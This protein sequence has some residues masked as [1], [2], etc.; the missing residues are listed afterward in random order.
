MI[1]YLEEAGRTASTLWTPYPVA[2]AQI[3][4]DTT[5]TRPTT[6]TTTPTTRA[7]APPTPP[8]TT[9]PAATPQQV[10]TPTRQNRRTAITITV[11]AT[12]TLA[13]ALS[14]VVPPP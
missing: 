11:I 3:H 5:R 9:R 13:S 1:K 2:P 12:A 14:P 4:P 6:A 10:Q 8:S 7:T